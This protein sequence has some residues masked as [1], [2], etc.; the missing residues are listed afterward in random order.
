MFGVLYGPKNITGNGSQLF[1]VCSQVHQ[2]TSEREMDSLAV[3]LSHSSTSAASNSSSSAGHSDKKETQ[4]VRAKDAWK[5]EE[6]WLTLS[7]CLSLLRLLHT[8]VRSSL[9]LPTTINN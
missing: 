5:E 8:T 3:R 2:A 1:I 9:P 7:E 6:G 4:G